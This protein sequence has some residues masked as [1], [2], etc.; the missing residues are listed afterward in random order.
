[1]R[2][3]MRLSL[4]LSLVMAAVWFGGNLFWLWI[5]SVGLPAGDPDLALV[6]AGTIENAAGPFVLLVVAVLSVAAFGVAAGVSW[7]DHRS[8][9]AGFLAG[10]VLGQIA[11]LGIYFGLPVSADQ[12]TT[13][14][15]YGVREAMVSV[16]AALVSGLVLA[17]A[18]LAIWSAARSRFV[19]EF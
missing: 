13:W 6:A 5:V 4:A 15:E 10:C 1:M 16:L 18:G 3:L 11:L 14:T 17:L 12:A 9:A 19:A 2:F 7:S 8:S